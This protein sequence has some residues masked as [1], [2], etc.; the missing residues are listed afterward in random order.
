MIECEDYN[1]FRIQPADCKLQTPLRLINSCDYGHPQRLV[2]PSITT[3]GL[4]YLSTPEN[5]RTVSCYLEKDF[6]RV[7]EGRERVRNYPLFLDDRILLHDDSEGFDDK[8]FL[9]WSIL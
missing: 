9:C 4:L 2:Y 5:V 1:F 8:E 3:N 7:W 6:S